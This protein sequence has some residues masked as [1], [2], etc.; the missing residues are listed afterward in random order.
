MPDSSCKRVK[1]TDATG[2]SCKS[3]FLPHI[4]DL[5]KPEESNF[6]P[7]FQCLQEFLDSPY[8]WHFLQC[9]SSRLQ[10][11]RSQMQR[12]R[13]RFSADVKTWDVAR[14]VA[15]EN[16]EAPDG[17][18]ILFLAG[19]RRIA[20]R[21]AQPLLTT[22]KCLTG[23]ENVVGWRKPKC[24]WE[25]DSLFEDFFGE[26]ASECFSKELIDR[27]VLRVVVK[28]LERYPDSRD[29]QT[30]QNIA[31][32]ALGCLMEYTRAKDDA[33]SEVGFWSLSKA[34]YRHVRSPELL[35]LAWHGIVKCLKR[36]VCMSEFLKRGGISK[37]CRAL[38]HHEN[39]NLGVRDHLVKAWRIVLVHA[40]PCQ[41]KEDDVR[42]ALGALRID[43]ENPWMKRMKDHCLAFGHLAK[44]SDSWAT[45]LSDQG[46]TGMI[47]RYLEAIKVSND[48]QTVV[49]SRKKGL[50]NA[51]FALSHLKL[52][53]QYSLRAIRMTLWAMKQCKELSVQLHGVSLLSKLSRTDVAKA[54]ALDACEIVAAAMRDHA[55]ENMQ[56]EGCRALS[57]LFYCQANKAKLAAVGGVAILLNAIEHYPL[58]SIKSE[59]QQLLKL[60]SQ[61]E[62]AVALV[63]E[64]LRCVKLFSS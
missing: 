14:L 64:P 53:P 63:P 19:A 4:E 34:A 13:E 39:V 29:D 49:M 62:A 57:N 26:D 12:C 11:V 61:D 2:P 48:E 10:H 25:L 60:M 20:L 31:L 46:L 9:A 55:H 44:R 1:K 17:D 52:D 47:V 15:E 27:G 3:E 36:G 43:Q 38:R 24:G 33:A 7:L 21:M 28:L 40:E 18:R 45:W 16:K 51:T 37:I 41:V 8:D 5:L 42:M 22:L 35:G 58:S 6:S 30:L 50:S 23:N 56:S 54:T 59:G 32:R